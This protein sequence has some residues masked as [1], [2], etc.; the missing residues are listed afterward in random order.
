MNDRNGGESIFPNP[1]TGFTSS[2]EE[3]VLF[4]GLSGDA[5]LGEYRSFV[6]RS[7]AESA[8]AWTLSATIRGTVVWVEEGVFEGRSTSSRSYDDDDVTD[9][10]SIYDDDHYST[11]D[12]DGSLASRRLFNVYTF[13][14][15]SSSRDPQSDVFTVNL[16][17]YDAVGC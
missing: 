3:Y 6:R 17:S 14:S 4:S 5:M 11:Y 13:T 12:D 10:G 1:D 15:Y 16:V 2:F 9:D 7:Y 8:I